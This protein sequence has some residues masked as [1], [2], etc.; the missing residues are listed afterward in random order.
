LAGKVLVPLSE[1]LAAGHAYQSCAHARTGRLCLL[2]RV[3]ADFGFHKNILLALSAS[4]IL[5]PLFLW[6][7]WRYSALQQVNRRYLAGEGEEPEW[8]LRISVAFCS[9]LCMIAVVAFL[10]AMWVFT[11]SNAHG[12]LIELGFVRTRQRM[13]FILV[14]RQGDDLEV[15]AWNWRPTIEFLRVEGIIDD[16]TSELMTLNGCG[17]QA[18]ADLAGRM[19]VAVERKLQSMHPGRKDSRLPVCH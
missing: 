18:D 15:N 8:E 19:A 16:E 5:L 2:V 4:S 9:L 17:A 14:P 12:V 11:Q 6:I 1:S 10:M 13:S 3:G 7:L